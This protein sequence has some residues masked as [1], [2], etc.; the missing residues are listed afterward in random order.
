MTFINQFN[1]LDD[2]LVLN[3]QKTIKLVFFL[4][5][6]IVVFFNTHSEHIIQTFMTK[7]I[8]SSKHSNFENL[9]CVF[10]KL[11]IKILASDCIQT[12]KHKLKH[13]LKQNS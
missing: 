7:F 4:H 10:F 5:S 1:I 2:V 11:K 3:L 12:L 8:R 13:K 6:S 9:L